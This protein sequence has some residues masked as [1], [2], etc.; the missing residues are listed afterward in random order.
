LYIYLKPIMRKN[1]K[2]AIAAG[3]VAAAAVYLIRKST[4]SRRLKK[5]SDDGYETA[6]DVLFPGRQLSTRKMKYGPVVPRNK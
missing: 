2:I 4:V 5:V 1:V 3:L 6:G